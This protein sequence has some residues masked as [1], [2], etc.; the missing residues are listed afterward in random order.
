MGIECKGRLDEVIKSANL[1][2]V[3]FLEETNRI[4][5]WDE[6]LREREREREKVSELMKERRVLSTKVRVVQVNDWM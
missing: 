3:F 1:L 2:T 4:G 6:I 5:N